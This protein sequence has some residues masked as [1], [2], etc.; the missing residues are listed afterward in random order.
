[1]GT[2]LL[3]YGIIRGVLEGY[4]EESFWVSYIFAAV[5]VIIGIWLIKNAQGSSAISKG[6]RTQY[7]SHL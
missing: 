4:R 6:E 7:H 3:G 5:A 1:V 2:Y